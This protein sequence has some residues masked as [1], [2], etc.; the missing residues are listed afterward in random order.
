MEA[1]AREQALADGLPWG[2]SES[3]SDTADVGSLVLVPSDGF[4]G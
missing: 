1:A 4:R 2:D 3:D